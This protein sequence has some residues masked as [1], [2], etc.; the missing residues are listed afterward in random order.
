MNW[1]LEHWQSVASLG[2][3]ALTVLL[4]IRGLTRRKARPGCG[5]HCGCGVKPRDVAAPR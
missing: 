5:G 2:V 1:F 3:V 4:F